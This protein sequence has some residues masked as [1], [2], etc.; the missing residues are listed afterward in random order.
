MAFKRSSVRSRPAPRLSGR[1]AVSLLIVVN[2][3]F[4]FI[5]STHCQVIICRF[6]LYEKISIHHFVG[7]GL[8]WKSKV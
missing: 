8:F 5:S 1:E 2:Y 3:R 4:L 6:G 7:W